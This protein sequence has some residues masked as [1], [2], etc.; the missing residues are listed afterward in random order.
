MLDG[1]SKTYAMTG[2]R[3][4]YAILPRGPRRRRSRKLIINSVSCTSSFSQVAAVEAL[5]GPQDD[6]DAMV[7]EFRAPARR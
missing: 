6:V 7:E 1:F 2:W 5:T 4:G 3:L